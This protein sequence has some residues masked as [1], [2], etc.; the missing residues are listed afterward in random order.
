MSAP[1]KRQRLDSASIEDEKKT[2]ELVRRVTSLDNIPTDILVTILDFLSLQTICRIRSV[3]QVFESTAKK[4]L[5]RI[6]IVDCRDMALAPNANEYRTILTNS[7]K[8]RLSG[9]R[10]TIRDCCPNVE[11]LKLI[12]YDRVRIPCLRE[13]RKYF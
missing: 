2:E 13:L 8:D 9:I 5:R 7:E 1:T 3:S 11:I 6:T 12:E 10:R 4:A